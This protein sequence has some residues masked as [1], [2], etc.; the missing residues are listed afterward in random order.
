MKETATLGGCMLLLLLF[1][2]YFLSQY[3]WTGW[4]NIGF[5]IFL[6]WIAFIIYDV[7]SI[8]IRQELSQFYNKSNPIQKMEEGEATWEVLYK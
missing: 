8:V 4:W 1:D 5:N 3:S 7:K 2:I 6:F